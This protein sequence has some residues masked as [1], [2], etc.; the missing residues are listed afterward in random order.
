MS[1]TNMNRNG[2][3][4]KPSG[5]LNRNNVGSVPYATIKGNVGPYVKSRV[6]ANRVKAAS[7][8]SLIHI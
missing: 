5:V 1:N 4:N 8:L 6:W 7:N 3:N 2:N